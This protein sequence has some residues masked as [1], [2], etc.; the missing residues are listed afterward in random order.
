MNM[1]LTCARKWLTNVCLPI[2]LVLP[3]VLVVPAV[4]QNRPADPHL[5]GQGTLKV[6]TYNMDVGTDY[7]GMLDRNLAN[8][9][10]GATNMVL[11]I[12][13][14]DPAGRAQAIAREI[15]ATKPHLISLQ[16]VSTLSTGPTKNNLTSEFDYLQ[17]LLQALSAQGEQY[18][19]VAWSTTWDATVPTLTGF[20]RGTWS[21]YILARADLDP[22]DFSFA[23]SQGGTFNATFVPHLYALDNSADCPVP[24]KSDGTCR[25][26]WPR[27]WAYTDVFYREKR[28]RIIGAHLDSSS[29]LL[30]IPQGV[31]LLSG[32]ANTSLPVIVAADLNCDCSNTADLM[33][34]T[35]ENFQK[36]GFTDAWA[37]TYP[38][39][40]GYTKHLPELNQRSD[41]VM[42]RG[43]FHVQAADIV[44]DQVSDKTESGLWPSDHAG[45]VARIQSPGEN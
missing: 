32:P 12:R 39:V 22:A 1:T 8:F 4:G 16:E 25:M 24:L 36:A 45:V 37:A 10:Q 13:A 14:S 19:P 33:F 31:E 7:A 5:Q 43:R 26:P 3:L 41:Y 2:P 20:A 6:M 11:S 29:P 17:L 28:F 44:G 38:G 18:V 15:V 27:G 21:I 30:E 23:G 9:L 42:V 40:A 34:A 35:C